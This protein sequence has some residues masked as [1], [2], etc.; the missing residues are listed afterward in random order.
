MQM[1][2]LTTQ[3]GF[4]GRT[5]TACAVGRRVGKWSRESATAAVAELAW[6]LALPVPVQEQEWV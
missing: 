4:L 3:S 1:C 6:E 2:R 5:M